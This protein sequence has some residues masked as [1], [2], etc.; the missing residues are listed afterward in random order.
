MNRWT[1]LA[2]TALTAMLLPAPAPADSGSQVAQVVI[3]PKESPQ[4]FRN[5]LKGIL[6]TPDR[7][8]CSMNRVYVPWCEIEDSAADGVDKVVDYT[9]KNWSGIAKYNAK[10]IPRVFLE[11]PMG[12]GGG[13]AEYAI[14]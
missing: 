4:A 2:L 5:P 11:W 12:T 6:G 10:V 14:F 3:R 7:E 1:I 13:E 9:N 8:F